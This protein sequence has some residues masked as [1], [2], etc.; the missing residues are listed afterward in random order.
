MSLNCVRIRKI[1]TITVI[2]VLSIPVIVTAD[3]H[4]LSFINNCNQP[5]WVNVQGGPPGTCDVPPAINIDP[6]TGTNLKCSACS[7]CPDQSLC[8]TS[9]STGGSLPMCCPLITDP[10][11][12]WG[13]ESCS[14][15]SC[16]PGFHRLQVRPIHAPESA[17]QMIN[18][19]RIRP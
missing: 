5:V 17:H 2:L 16:C 8:N 12:C 14:K 10:P 1:L 18:T 6:G 4:Q 15:G 9:V 19:V 7:L 3:S 11:V 13:G